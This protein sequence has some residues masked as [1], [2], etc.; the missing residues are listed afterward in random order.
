MNKKLIGFM[1]ILTLPL[2]AVAEMNPPPQ[3][4]ATEMSP[5]PDSHKRV[6]HLTKE[7]GLTSDQQV[8][9]EAIFNTQREKMKAAHQ[10]A[11]TALKAVFTPEQQTKFEAIQ[12]KHKAMR[13][14]RMSA[15][16]AK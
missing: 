6:E 1:L 12:D 9:V 11:Q 13:R 5:P 16:T 2:V 8:K 10:E 4:P 15:K 3:P 7:L 14:E